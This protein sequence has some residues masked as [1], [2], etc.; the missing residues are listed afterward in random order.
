MLRSGALVFDP[1]GGGF[2]TVAADDYEVVD[3]RKSS[4]WIESGGETAFAEFFERYF[5]ENLAN[6]A[7]REKFIVESCLELFDREFPRDELETP[8]YYGD[9]LV[10]CPHCGNQNR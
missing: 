8:K 5:M 4:F 9:G 10:R 7:P 1:T 6:Q 3:G 2:R